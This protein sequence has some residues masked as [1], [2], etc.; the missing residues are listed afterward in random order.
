MLLREVFNFVPRE[1]LVRGRHGPP[2]MPSLVLPG[3]VRKL[4]AKSLQ[5]QTYERCYYRLCSGCCSSIQRYRSKHARSSATCTQ[6]L[7]H[8]RLQPSTWRRSPKTLPIAV[9]DNETLLL[10]L[11]DLSGQPPHRPRV[12]E[13]SQSCNLIHPL[14]THQPLSDEAARRQMIWNISMLNRHN[15][16][17]NM[18][19][20]G[21][22]HRRCPGQLLGACVLTQQ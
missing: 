6:R 3:S 17:R 4:P 15:S 13:S 21:H 9:I 18:L 14:S 2:P 8:H 1:W 19:T 22:L 10:N 7:P 12:I 11:I 16:A 5:P 20:A